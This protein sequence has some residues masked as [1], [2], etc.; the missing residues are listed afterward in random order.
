MKAKSHQLYREQVFRSYVGEA[1]KNL[2]ENTA[3]GFGREGAVYMSKSYADII[4]PP[5]EPT[6]TAEEI[7]D[8]I[9]QKLREYE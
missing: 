3:K 4:S 1:L 6:R 9:K 7:I 8:G 2:S 5:K